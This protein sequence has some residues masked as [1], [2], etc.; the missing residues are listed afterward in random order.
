MSEK[1]S[2]VRKKKK[3]GK[4]Y[5][6]TPVIRAAQLSEESRKEIEKDL[7]KTSGITPQ[8]LAHKYGIKVSLAKKILNHFQ[9]KGS[10]SAA[11]KSA[12][13]QVYKS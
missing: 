12:K 5:E 13:I 1:S 8:A 6:Y 4:V 9:Q 10:I 7:Q 2:V 11:H 3:W